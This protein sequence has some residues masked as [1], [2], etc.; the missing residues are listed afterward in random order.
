MSRG[1]GDCPVDFF[2]TLNM[3]ICLFLSRP[4]LYKICTGIFV[5]F[6]SDFV[7]ISLLLLLDMEN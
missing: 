4:R 2:L 6:C 1:R 3:V 5:I 7:K